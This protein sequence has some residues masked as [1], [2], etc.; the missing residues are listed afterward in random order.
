MNFPN[1]LFAGFWNMGPG[2]F[3]ESENSK[4]SWSIHSEWAHIK[5]NGLETCRVER[6][7]TPFYLSMGWMLRFGQN[8]PPTWTPPSCLSTW[9]GL[10]E[11]LRSPGLCTLTIWA[12]H[13]S[14]QV[15][16]INPGCLETNNK[17]LNIS[18][19][20]DLTKVGSIF[21]KHILTMDEKVLE[22]P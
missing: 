11:I 15:W 10:L 18:W 14:M 19:G 7:G 3:L 12:R 16:S 5:I 20:H 6:C 13:Q 9:V 1:P 21:D 2:Y 4:M 17:E 8:G 22:Y